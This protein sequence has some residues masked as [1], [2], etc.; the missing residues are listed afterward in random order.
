[1]EI[2]KLKLLHD[3]TKH[4]TTLSTGAI[5]ILVAFYEKIPDS[6]MVHKFIPISLIFFV[7]CI[8]SATFAQIIVIVSHSNEDKEY[9]K[10]TLAFTD[11]VF[12]ASW[13]TFAAGMVS[14]CIAGL[15]GL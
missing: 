4:V 10:N 9:E 1:M 8:L 7:A 3:H 13:L 15:F 5:L 12:L 11:K 2:E 6:P 14:L